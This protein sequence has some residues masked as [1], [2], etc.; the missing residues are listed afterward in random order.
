MIVREQLDTVLILVI[1][2]SVATNIV[3]DTARYWIQSRRW[4]K[5]MED[6]RSCFT[7]I[8][9]CKRKPEGSDE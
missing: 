3:L 2:V 9:N 7:V 6:H 5:A 4:R 8:H 1:L